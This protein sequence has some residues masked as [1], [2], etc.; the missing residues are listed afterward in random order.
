MFRVSRDEMFFNYFVD[1]A[2]NACKA[3]KMLEDL[4]VNYVNVNEKINAIEEIE[5]EGDRLV[6]TILQ[7]LHRSFITP[8]DRED[9]D[10]IAKEI[11]NITD[12]IE[13]TAHRFNMFNIATI[14]EDAKTLAKLISEAVNEVKA[15]MLELKNMKKSKVLKEKIILINKLENDGDQVF[16]TAI[17]KLFLTSK[18]ALEVVK[19]KEIYEYL[20]NALD[21]CEDVA[22][23]VE[24]VVTKHA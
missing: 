12:S 15:L 14:P 21:A 4:M 19:W 8:I 22:N 20:E 6:H 7:A 9:I 13:S 2:E 16:R 24:G 3:G 5:H 1:T 23:I 11:D 18:D 10:L 17:T